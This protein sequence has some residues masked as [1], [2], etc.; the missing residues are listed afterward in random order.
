MGHDLR[1]RL[2]GRYGGVYVGIEV[3]RLNVYTLIL[4]LFILKADYDYLR[5]CR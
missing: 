5:D 3:K 4:G 1:R 2:T